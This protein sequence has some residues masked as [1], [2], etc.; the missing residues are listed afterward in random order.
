MEAILE[1]RALTVEY[2]TP[3]GL[4]AR[5]RGQAPVVLRALDQAEVAVERGRSLGI[6]GESGC[7]KSTLA[8]AIVGLV[9]P[10]SGSIWLDGRELPAA[11]DPGTRRRVQMVF[12]DPSSALN[13]ALSISKV[14]M[15]LLAVHGIASGDRAH[16]RCEELM[17]AVELPPSVLSAYPRSL[18][19]GQRQRIG[20][21]RAL[22]LEPDVL[23]ADEAVASL[24][25]S[26]Q[27][28]VIN[29]LLGLQAQL[30]LTL[31]IISH[32]LA[33]V[34]QACDQVAVMYLGRVVERGRTEEVFEDP[35]HPYTQALIRAI[36]RLA[37]RE[38]RPSLG[39]EPP[40]PLDLPSGCRFHT[41]CVRAEPS[42][43]ATTEPQLSGPRG[44]A[45]HEAACHFAW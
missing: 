7:G 23:I 19:G 10:T 28:A 13:P 12:Q 36:P 34:R 20:I 40:S 25:V 37:A 38:R 30:G 26:L 41:R 27:A 15:E 14:L 11:R 9:A 17:R 42:V 24:D 39:G 1:T 8:R 5:A 3:T 31:I 43:C 29:V 16:A 18:S 21:A 35:R 6:V 2:P 22:A 44:P 32:D 4:L 33:I 45:G